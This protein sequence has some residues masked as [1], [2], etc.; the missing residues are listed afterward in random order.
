MKKENS[1]TKKII[2]D[3]NKKGLIKKY[4]NYAETKEGK[5]TSMVREEEEYYM[6]LEK[7]RKNEKI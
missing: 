1:K 4:S 5:L 2:E 6:E 7:R 3:A